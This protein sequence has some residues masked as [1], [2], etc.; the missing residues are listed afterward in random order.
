MK[1]NAFFVMTI[2][3]FALVACND[4]KSEDDT[5]DAIAVIACEFK[6]SNQVTKGSNITANLGCEVPE[7]Y[8]GLELTLKYDTSL[9]QLTAGGATQTSAGQVTYK[10]PPKENFESALT[11]KGLSAGKGKL[12]L[13]VNDLSV[14]WD[15]SVLLPPRAPFDKIS[16]SLGNTHN[17][18]VKDGELWAWGNNGSGQLGNGG[19]DEVDAPTKIGN[20]AMVEAGITHSVAIREDGTLWTWG[21][22]DS[23]E[24]GNGGKDAD[25]DGDADNVLMPSIIGS[26][27]D[28]KTV[29]AASHVLAIK[30]DGTLW[31]WGNNISGK[32]GNGGL[33]PDSDGFPADVLTPAQVGSDKDWKSVAAG[34]EHSLAIKED[35]TLWAW[36]NNASGQ[37]G[38]GGIDADSDGAFDNVLTPAQIGSDKDWKA[39]FAGRHS[40]FAIK[41]DG[42]LWAWGYNRRGQLGLGNTTNQSSPVKVGTATSWKAVAGGSNGDN[43]RAH[44]IG[45]REDGTLW[46]WGNDWNGQLGNGAGRTNQTSPQQI[47]SDTDWK[48]IAA[49]N[50]A[51]MAVKSDDSFWTWGNDL[52][53]QAG[54]G[55]ASSDDVHTPTKIN[56]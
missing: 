41:K 18:A 53:G 1:K 28:W 51:S 22:N 48:A 24:L 19:T 26:D 27:K 35:G 50:A 46:A 14:S 16:I 40:S 9:I 6:G 31:A 43:E 8:Q 13:N 4:D 37:L 23:G 39:A 12:N 49:G 2:L 38:N 29:A 5:K 11:L 17:L 54:N 15:Y 52:W 34:D 44:T 21:S 30:T 56:F 32:L 25:S 36:G 3:S 42:T 10:L 7:K 20:Y 33:N 55:A 45:L 47:G